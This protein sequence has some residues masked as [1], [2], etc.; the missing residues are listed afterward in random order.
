MLVIGAKELEAN[1]VAV[2]SRKAGD[3][4]QM[5]VDDF[6]AKIKEEIETK[7]RD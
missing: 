6:V 3:V 5:L 1:A 7:A 2:R 4:G